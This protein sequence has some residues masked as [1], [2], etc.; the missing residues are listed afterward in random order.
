MRSIIAFCA[1]AAIGSLVTYLL[2]KENSDEIREQ[3]RE[4]V[5]RAYGFYD[6]NEEAENEA[7]EIIS[8]EE[9][10]MYRKISKNTGYDK[11]FDSTG[12]GM[13]LDLR[14]NYFN[15]SASDFPTTMAAEEHP[16]DE[17]NKQPYAIS[18][19]EYEAD[20]TVLRTA[21]GE[22]IPVTTQDKITLTY[23]EGDDTLILDSSGDVLNIEET[24]GND[25]LNRFGEFEKDTVYVRN[26]NLGAD[27][28]VVREHGKYSKEVL[29]FDE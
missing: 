8:N 16:T 3:E 6:Q 28:E 23:Y 22:D 10:S 14:G 24:V 25:A 20:D 13:E 9:A 4:S 2:V 11:M 26:L 7:E 21:E 29:G 1:G 15:D 12:L 5:K 27:Y 19:E 18:L 17:D